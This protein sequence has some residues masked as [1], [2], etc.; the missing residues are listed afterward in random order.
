MKH[1]SLPSAR[2]IR[3]RSPAASARRRFRVWKYAPRVVGHREPG[4]GRAERVDAH[5]LL[6]REGGDVALAKV[7]AAEPNRDAVDDE[8]EDRRERSLRK[9]DAQRG[10]DASQQIQPPLEVPAAEKLLGRAAPQIEGV[11]VRRLGGELEAYLGGL[12]GAA[13][14]AERLGEL[15]LD[16]ADVHLRARAEREDLAIETRG[17]IERERLDRSLGRQQRV[18]GRA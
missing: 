13:R 11:H 4:A 8:E 2:M 18:V 9:R 7:E 15:P 6:A 14:V 10:E 5:D 16:P 1:T 3:V 12:G 17:A